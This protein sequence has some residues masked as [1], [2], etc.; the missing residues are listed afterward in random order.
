MAKTILVT[1]ASS[2]IGMATAILLAQN[3]YKMY[4]AARRINKLQSLKEYGI[5]PVFL[6]I[7]IATGLKQA[8][9]H[10]KTPSRRYSLKWM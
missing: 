5:K 9:I 4:G 10:F 1:G 2:G 8:C 7:A 3:G 6:D